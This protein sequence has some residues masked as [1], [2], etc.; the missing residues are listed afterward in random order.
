MGLYRHMTFVE[1]V[2]A[3]K[4]TGTQEGDTVYGLPGFGAANVPAAPAPLATMLELE[5][6]MRGTP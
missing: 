1:S 4:I 2:Q 3:F 5:A 6:A